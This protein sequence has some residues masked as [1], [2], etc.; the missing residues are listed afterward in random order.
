MTMTY[1]IGLTVWIVLGLLAWAFIHGATRKTND[2]RLD[3]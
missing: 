1:L 2:P 3:R